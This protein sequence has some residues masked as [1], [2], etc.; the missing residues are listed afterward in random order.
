MTLGQRIQEIRVQHGFSQEKFAEKLGTTRQTVSRW[1]LDQTYP[2]IAKIVMISKLFSVSTD[3][4]IKD[5]IS[6]FDIKIDSF[7]CGVYRSQNSEIVETEK[8]AFVLYC[9]GDKAHLGVMLYEGYGDEKQLVA[10]IE[11]DKYDLGVEYAYFVK[12][13]YPHMAISNSPKLAKRLSEKYDST[14]KNAMSCVESF[15]VD[16]RLVPLPTVKDAGIPKCLAVWRMSDSYYADEEAFNFHLCT[17]KV[18]YDLSIN[19]EY[20]EVCC[21]ASYNAVFDLGLFCGNPFFNLRSNCKD[22]NKL[23]MNHSDFSQEFKEINIPVEKYEPGKCIKTKYGFICGVKRYSD[24]EV[25]L[26]GCDNDEY[27]YCRNDKRI[28]RFKNN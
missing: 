3:S 16:H 21:R 1:E 20:S 15:I 26:Q 17:E 9:S 12:D 22:E 4:I 14:T 13:S 23:Y 19:F 6:T 2:E 11:R 8:F 18:E 27:I 25:V 5:G 28:E 7:K 10:I 24:D